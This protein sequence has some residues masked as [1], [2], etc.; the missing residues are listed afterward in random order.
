MNQLHSLSK[1]VIFA[2]RGASACA[3]ENTLAS[4]QLAL[5][6]HAD[7]IELDAK[8]SSD[9]EIMVIHDQTVDRTTGCH[10]K[11]NRLCLSDLKKLDA[12]S[13][14]SENYRGEKI[15]TLKEVFECVGKKLLINVELTNYASPLDDL[16]IKTAELVIA[17]GLQDWVIFSSFSPL[18]LYRMRR[19]LPQAEVAVLAL[20]GRS[21]KAART[22]FGKL[23]SPKM[24][25]PF[26]TDATQT[27][28]QDQ[29]AQGRRVHVWTVND[30]EDIKRL[31]QDKVDGI[32]TDNPQAA[33]SF[34]EKA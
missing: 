31:A 14:F 18:N 28:I 6:Q 2:H 32:F 13:S 24:V 27:Y 22:W 17:H 3:P 21:G 34:L 25:H 20:P 19:I 29:H 30:P 16:P 7:A 9:G 8:L 15:P 12:G 5:N 4:F 33:R 11:V 23:F 26:L 1:P 10:G